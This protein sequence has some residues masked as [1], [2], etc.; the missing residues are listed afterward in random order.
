[1]MDLAIWWWRLVIWQKGSTQRQVHRTTPLGGRETVVKMMHRLN[2][3][4]KEA[5]P[6][7]LDDEG[8]D[9]LPCPEW[10][11]VG[12]VMAPN[13]LHINTIWSVV[14]PAWGN[15]KGLVV[16]HLGPNMFMAEFGSEEDRS[17]VA[18]GGPWKTWNMFAE[19]FPAGTRQSMNML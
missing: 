15:H 7:A 8:D 5:D 4:S 19:K 18:K 11:L 1:M 2:L 13:T 17:R 10:A 6:M 14:R 16:N 12:K 3:T 9:D